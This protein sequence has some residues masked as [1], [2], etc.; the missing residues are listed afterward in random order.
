MNKCN[1]NIMVMKNLRPGMWMCTCCGW[2]GFATSSC[3]PCPWSYST[4]SS[5]GPLKNTLRS[6]WKSWWWYV[7]MFGILKLVILN[8]IIVRTIEKYVQ[9]IKLMVVLV[10]MF[11]QGYQSCQ[12]CWPPQNFHNSFRSILTRWTRVWNEKGQHN[13]K[14]RWWNYSLWS[15]PTHNVCPSQCLNTFHFLYFLLKQP[16]TRI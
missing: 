7:M 6:W 3:P 8:T 1:Y 10:M 14:K 11:T 9:V 16:R 2:L 13:F 4:P 15:S 12:R 5:S